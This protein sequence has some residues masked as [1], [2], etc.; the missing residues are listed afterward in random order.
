[1]RDLPEGT[2]TLLLT[3]IEGSTRMLHSLGDRYADVLAAHREILRKAFASHGGVEVDTQ[4]D[5]FF[6]A[7]PSAIGCLRAA[8]ESQRGLES[9]DWPEGRAVRVRMGMH[10]GE[11]TRIGEGY[12]GMDV[13]AAA[14]ICSAGHGGQILLS[15]RT[16]EL[17]EE[18][19]ATEELTLRDLGEHRLKDLEGPQQLFQ[20][21]IPELSS[22]FS[23]LRTLETRPNNLPT[24][25]T[26]FIGRAKEVTEVRDLLLRDG[27][28]V[29]TLTGP[30]G[31]GKSR[32]A[33]RVATELLHSFADGAFFVALASVRRHALVMS[34]LARAL[35]VRE[36]QGRTLQEALEDHLRDRAIL[37]VF[38]NFEHV[39]QAG[40]TL[41]E[42]MAQCPGVK[43][44]ITSREALRLSGEYDVPVPPWACPSEGGYHRCWSWRATRRSGSSSIGPRPR[45]RISRS[46]TR[47]PRP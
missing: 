42:L 32:L 15:H 3:D 4:G 29:V 45:G 18:G 28:R 13:H 9:Y 10:T 37:L 17:A 1:M 35:G 31:T 2:V 22:D 40:R 43:V 26:P 7:F 5:A 24:P 30:G 25:P 34:A 44:L 6:V 14:R 41:A 19:L 16:A 12:V 27:V 38:D 46:T 36:G 23:P 33:L 21:V 47:T 20:V 8:V 11:P 39:R